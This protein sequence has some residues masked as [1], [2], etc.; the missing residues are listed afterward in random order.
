MLKII[1][2]IVLCLLGFTLTGNPAIADKK[3]SRLYAVPSTNPAVDPAFVKAYTQDY[4]RDIPVMIA[5]IE[6]ESGFR[7]YEADGRLLVSP[8]KGS[9]ASGAAQILYITH[10]ADWSDD[11]DTNITTLS[12]N[13]AYARKMYLESGTSPWNESIGCWGPKIHKYEQR[14]ADATS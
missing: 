8:V 2:T 6:C 4:F 13:L 10:K 12:G 14:V 7:Q 5:I 3:L 11:P 9:S 1:R